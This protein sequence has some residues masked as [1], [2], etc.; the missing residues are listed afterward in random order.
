METVEEGEKGK[1]PVEI[2]IVT[3]LNPND[4]TVAIQEIKKQVFILERWMTNIINELLMKHD[5]LFDKMVT[6]VVDL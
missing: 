5:H 1:N 3:P 6:M 2:L 4:T